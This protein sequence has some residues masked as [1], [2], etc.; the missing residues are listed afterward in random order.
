[1]DDVLTALTLALTWVVNGFLV[2]LYTM[3]E[4]VLA[5]FLI[6]AMIWLTVD[7]EDSR[8]P[9]MMA[10]SLLTMT[11]AFFAPPVVGVWLNLMGYASI[12]AILVEKFDRASLRWRVV[13]GL[14]TYSLVGL[15]FLIYQVL[16]PVLAAEGGLFAQGQGYLNVIISIA[17]WLAPL[18][19][20]GILVQGVL[21]HPPEPKAPGDTI[22]QIR[23]RGRR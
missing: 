4:Y 9:W 2:I 3:A 19:Y 13:G 23:T 1:M 6:P 21:V 17:V 18:A 20:L 10:T 7:I 22:H 14:T 5:L 11:V 15:G 16:T 8:R 12:L